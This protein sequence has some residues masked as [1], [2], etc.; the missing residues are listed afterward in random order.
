MNRSPGWTCGRAW[1]PEVL[2]IGIASIM[3]FGSAT[4]TGSAEAVETGPAHARP[5][6]PTPEAIAALPPDGGPLFNRLVFEKSPYLLQ[7]AA[8][9][10][11]W[12]PWGPAAFEKARKENKPI[13]LSVGYST[14][15]WCHV[16]EHES[17]EDAEVS[18][19]MNQYFVCVKVDREERPDV[20][21]VY[22][23]VTQ[24]MT[25]RG[26]WP[27]TVLMTPDK[28]PFFSGTYFPKRN[29]M[30]LLP[31]LHRAW[32]EDRDRINET[33]D[34][35][36]EHLQSIGAP[37]AG[38][39]LIEETLHTTFKDFS[40]RF[41]SR[42]GG[43]SKSPKFPVPHNLLFLLAYWH[44]TNDQKALAMVEKTLYEMR[45]GG[46]YDHVGFGFHRYSTDSEWFLPHFEKM[47][48]D[49]ALLT[50]AFTSAFQATGKATY[51]ETAREILAYVL[52][53]MTSPEG[54]FYCA[55]DADSEGEEG[56]FYLWTQ[57]Q[58]KEIVGDDDGQ[59][60]CDVYNITRGGTY[61]EEASGAESGASIPHLKAS[62]DELAKKMEIGPA[63]LKERVES[64]RTRLFIER[65]KRIH[66]LKDD[67]IL[68][69]WNGLMMSAMARA[70]QALQEKRYTDA[71]RR[72]ADFVLAT[73]R[74]SDG[75]LMKRYRQGE[76]RFPG[77]LEDY[78]F[79][80]MGLIDVYEAT[81]Q[82]VYL[83][84]AVDLADTMLEH[85][86][87]PEHGAF[88][89]TADDGE[90]LIVRSKEIYDG[91]IPS[92]NSVAAHDLVRLSRLTGNTL[93]ATRADELMKSFSGMVI[94]GP[95]NFSMFMTALD[96]RVGPSLEI[97]ISG[98]PGAEDSLR[99]IREVQTRFLPRR[100]L[101]FRP[102]DVPIPEIAKLA[103][104][105]KSMKPK[106]N[107]ATAYV[108]RNFACDLPTTNV[109][110][111]LKSIERK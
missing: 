37:Q 81:Q 87:D 24:A 31:A 105:T 42:K 68:T 67:K 99:M 107:A 18:K 1:Q 20:D 4:P 17:F 76:A 71:A 2:A 52:R 53:D 45:L 51:A 16:M 101:I 88:Y 58:V 72:S 23:T 85:F 43:F 12:Y 39:D 40:S 108:C 94:R 65:E 55:E 26:G 83:R 95:A 62:L 30:Q 13:F 73:L 97:V 74:S 102:G 63:A 104:Y 21:H 89:L 84:A 46:I 86:W 48:Y 33:G 54:G 78:A 3:M 92:G 35:I 79:L 41:D 60:Y 109:T 80:V 75:R 64:I 77:H 10:V 103:P 91:A 69:D 9:P 32:T 66:P 19:L 90:E 47:L 93:Y 82:A 110:T 98:D 49:Q 56:K 29:M 25:G 28:R 11:D 44:R 14:C 34:Q 50:M 8:N 36:V 27:M 6:L 96:F 38:P 5:S 7:H 106:G 57:A 15:H 22:M 61:H 59:F 100:V 70:G 111:M